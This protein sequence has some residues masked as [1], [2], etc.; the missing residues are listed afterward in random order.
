MGVC[1]LGEVYDAKDD[2]SD[3]LEIWYVGNKPLYLQAFKIF[4]LTFDFQEEAYFTP[5]T[6]KER[7][8]WNFL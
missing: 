4:F 3:F 1:V 5:K 8:K 7:L 2:W 6:P